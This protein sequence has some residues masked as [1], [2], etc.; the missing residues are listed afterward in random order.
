MRIAGRGSPVFPGPAGT[1]VPVQPFAF[2]GTV[3]P[4]D[5]GFV[6]FAFEKDAASG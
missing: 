3:A 6:E 5:N 2:Q 1:R 4:V